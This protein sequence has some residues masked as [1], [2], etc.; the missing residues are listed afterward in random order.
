MEKDIE[1][2]VRDV[3]KKMGPDLKKTSFFM[4][5]KPEVS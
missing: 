5:N 4:S 2:V 3:I 1:K